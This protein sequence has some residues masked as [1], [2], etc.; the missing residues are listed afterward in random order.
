MTNTLMK[1]SR[2]KVPSST[3]SSLYSFKKL[4]TPEIV[5]GVSIICGC[6]SAGVYL[7]CRQGFCGARP[8]RCSLR[9]S[10][11]CVFEEP[12]TTHFALATE[13]FRTSSYADLSSLV[14][15][16]RGSTRHLQDLGKSSFFIFVT[17]T[18]LLLWCKGI[19]PPAES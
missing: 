3:L 8:C 2:E 17:N 6:L 4:A 1:L 5:I 15:S 9:Q 12:A 16:P 11:L 18:S 19:F 13:S 7:S 14:G 10:P